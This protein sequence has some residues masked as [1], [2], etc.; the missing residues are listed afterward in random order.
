MKILNN[1]VSLVVLA[2]SFALGLAGPISAFADPLPANPTAPV[3]GEAGRYVI[4]ANTIITTTGTTI[5]SNGDIGLTTY[6]RSTYGGFTPTGPAGD[7]TQLT[8]GTSYASDDANPSPFPYPLHYSTPVVGEPWTT[9]GAMLTQ[10]ATDLGIAYTFLAADPNQPPLAPTQVLPTELGNLTLTRGVYKTA[11]DVTIQTGTLHLNAQG[12]PNSVWIFSIDGNLTTGAP[13]GNIDFVDGI[14]QAKNVYWRVA[15][16]TTIGAGTT[17]Y[18]NVFNWAQVNVLAGAHITGRLFSANEQVTLISDTVTAP[19]DAPLLGTLAAEDFGVMNQSNVIGYT[20]GFGLTDATLADAQSVVVQLYSGETLLQTNTVTAKLATDY[21]ALTSFSGPFDVFGTFNYVADGYWTNVRGTEYGQNLVPTKVVAT[22]TLTNGKVVTATNENPTG[23]DLTMLGGPVFI[24]TNNDHIL[25]AG[26]SFFTT[27]QAAVNAAVASDTIYVTAGTYNENVNVNKSLTLKGASSAT[28]TVNAVSQ[29]D[30]VFTV[31]TSSVNISGFTIT[32]TIYTGNEGYAGIKFNNGVASCDIRDN[33][34]THNQY[35]ILLIDPEN[36]TTPG[37]NTFTNN[38]ASNNGVSGIEMQHTYGNTFTN[39][40]VNSNK[41]GFKLDSARH[42]IF[43]GNTANSNQKG[44]YLTTGEGVGSNDN[45]FTNNI[46]NLN[47]RYGLAFGGISSGTILTGNTFDSNV[48]SG[49]RL[50]DA[51]TGLDMQNNNI[52]NNPTGIDIA[53]VATNVT[54]WTVTHN[55]ISSSTTYGVS[56]NSTS[57]LNAENNWWG[58]GDQTGIPALVSSGVDFTPWCGNSACSAPSGSGPEVTTTLVSSVSEMATT[59]AGSVQIDVPSGMTI[60]GPNTWDGTFNTTPTVT[61]TFTLP[62]NSGF[63]ASVIEAIEVG[64]GDVHLTFDKAVKL[65]FIGQAEKLVGW[66]QAGVFHEITNI[67]DSPTTPTLGDDSDC[68]MNYGTDLYVWTKHFSTFITYALAS[69][70]SSAPVSSGGGG[71]GGGGGGFAGIPWDWGQN[72][73]SVATTQPVVTQ[74]A[75]GQVLGAATFNFAS[76]LKLGSQGNDVTEL[77]NR[78]AKEGVYSGPVTGYFG[79][80]T[81]AAV[82]AYQAKLGISTVGAVGPLT[83]AKLNGSV[84]AGV[85]TSA[86]DEAIKIQINQLQAQLVILLSQL[87]ELLKAQ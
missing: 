47:T 16:V 77:Q 1:K 66:S 22:V 46:V 65:V 31:A 20:A 27:I 26:E 2:V 45:T 85:S 54:S 25:N 23:G 48:I 64:A 5:I 67:C 72:V 51:V 14:G 3:L 76:D 81:Q 19:V 43:T 87:V 8:N 41:Y 58:T 80:L 75:I 21:P 44:F 53:T 70:S 18:G 11:A 55:N 40:I 15:G 34:L 13:G 71:G 82:K 61:S 7:L 36:T 6:A 60:T 42:N 78:L 38:D 9:T 28:V 4:L 83:R 69:I 79:T 86:K 30:S 74:P 50:E 29:T 52:T 62:T 10:S 39:N 24:D 63:T 17:F 49:V 84:V 33:V 32:H 35:G 73:A 37:N 57:T 68:K 12:D 56:N 59:S